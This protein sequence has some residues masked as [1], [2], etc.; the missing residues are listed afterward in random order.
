MHRQYYDDAPVNNDH[1]QQIATSLDDKL[2]SLQTNSRHKQIRN[3]RQTDLHPGFRL[4]NSL[5][6]EGIV[7]K[8]VKTKKNRGRH[9]AMTQQAVSEYSWI[10]FG[11]PPKIII[12]AG[13]STLDA[14]AATA[15]VAKNPD[16]NSS[17]KSTR[18]FISI[19]SKSPSAVKR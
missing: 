7:H 8:R 3:S 15:A 10:A 2:S 9:Q 6:H 12:S 5:I 16:Q 13:G 11:P 17:E 19:S 4:Y 18:S 14:T 1:I